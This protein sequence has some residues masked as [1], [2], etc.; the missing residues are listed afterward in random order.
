M[1]G[2][3]LQIH[4]ADGNAK[5]GFEGSTVKHRNAHQ[6]Y[7]YRVRKYKQ[8]RRRRRR[9]RKKIDSWSYISFHFET[10]FLKTLKNIF[11]CKNIFFIIQ[12]A[13]KYN[14]NNN[15]KKFWP[16]DS[17]RRHRGRRLCTLPLRR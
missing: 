17:N 5:T 4:L 12:S 9:R 16:K 14:N 6:S 1:K 3:P 10:I 7:F 15:K 2:T 11:Y 8:G 13:Q